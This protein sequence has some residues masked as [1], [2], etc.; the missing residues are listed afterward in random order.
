MNVKMP[1]RC[2]PSSQEHNVLVSWAL[3]DGSRCFKA[4]TCFGWVQLWTCRFCDTGSYRLHVFLQDLRHRP[5]AEGVRGDGG[6]LKH[7]EP[8]WSLWKET[9]SC[10]V[11]AW[12][13][14]PTSKVSNRGPQ[15]GAGDPS[16]G[17]EMSLRGHMRKRNPLFKCWTVYIFSGFVWM[18][19]FNVTELLWVK[20][21]ESPT[22]TSDLVS[23]NR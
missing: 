22:L 11:T 17:H 18:N 5:T 21:A 9:W 4:P 2:L 20:Q 6:C 13:P 12:R 1:S 10:S 23:T 3:T 14:T 15:H 7:T 19:H 8:G 16:V